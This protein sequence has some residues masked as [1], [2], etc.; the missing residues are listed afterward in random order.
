MS[1]Y[2]SLS[3]KEFADRILEIERPMI[4]IHRRPDGDTVGTATALATIYRLLGKKAVILSSDAIPKRLAF[5]PEE[6]GIEV[7]YQ[8][9]DGEYISVD[10]ASPEQLGTLSHLADKIKIMIDHHEV[11]K[12]FADSYIIP[13][14][15]SAAEVLFD[16]VSELIEMGKISLTRE[17]ASSLY[18]AISSDTGAFRYSNTSPR[19][20]RTAASLIE[21]GI[22]FASINHRLFCSKSGEELSAE[23]FVASSLKTEL[24]GAIAYV[25]ITRRDMDSLSL[26]D[27]HFETAVDVVR[28]LSGVKVAVA[29]KEQKDGAF[30]ASLRSTGANVAAVAEKFG[31]GGHIRASGCTLNKENGKEAID[32][33]ISEIKGILS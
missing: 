8:P 32:A 7:T 10:V 18:T 23:G 1:G 27:E 21:C 3:K 30:R 33:L 20:L 24:D 11:G 25:V 9:T 22:D 5:I 13:G 29:F 19:T 2:L 12:I 4:L 16:L 31:G 28:S 26:T 6:V 14:A 17:L 15:S